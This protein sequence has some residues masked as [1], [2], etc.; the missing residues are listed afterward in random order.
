MKRN[1]N[2]SY[3]S[4]IKRV[5]QALEDDVID[6]SEWGDCLLGADNVY[7]SDNLRK[8]YYVIKKILPKLTEVEGLTSDDVLDMIDSERKELYKDR[9]KARDQ[10]RE[11]NKLLT[12][13]ARFDNL[14]DVMKE[15]IQEM[16]P[17]RFDCQNYETCDIDGLEASLILS[18][19]HFGIQI[20]NRFNFYNMEVAEERLNELKNK[21]I[22]YCIKHNVTKLNIEL[23]GDLVSGLIHTG[24]RCQQEEDVMTQLMQ[25]SEILANLI[26][27]LQQ[28]IP[29]IVVYSVFGNHSRAIPNKKDSTTSE[30]FERLI[31]FYLRTR[32]GKGIKV[33]DSGN[34]DFW[35]IKLTGNL[36]C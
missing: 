32:L 9:V 28:H 31:P 11:L 2:E 3:Y 22:H 5:T 12:N 8:G 30:N 21:T 1:E 34:D 13:G 36:L 26:N 19:V 29:Q 18:D 25:I 33:L 6:Y 20:D 14:V 23:L 27:E 35:N 4:Y 16:K 15:S 17:L 10:R 7:S 24:V